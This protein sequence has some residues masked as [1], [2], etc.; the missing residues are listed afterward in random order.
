MKVTERPILHPFRSNWVLEV[1]ATCGKVTRHS[2]RTLDVFH[3][4][5]LAFALL[6]RF[7][8]FLPVKVMGVSKPCM[9]EETEIFKLFL[10]DIFESKAV[11]TSAI[12]LTFLGLQDNKFEDWASMEETWCPTKRMQESSDSWFSNEVFYRALEYQRPETGSKN[13]L[14]SFSLQTERT[15]RESLLKLHR[16]ITRLQSALQKQKSVLTFAR[17]ELID[18]EDLLPW[19][20][21]KPVCWRFQLSVNTGYQLGLT[22]LSQESRIRRLET[23]HALE[24]AGPG[25]PVGTLVALMQ[26]NLLEKYNQLLR[27][28]ECCEINLKNQLLSKSTSSSATVTDKY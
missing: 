26:T 11:F 19:A 8:E 14:A 9:E 22:L 21:A 4:D 2:K 24:Q 17:S 3:L 7:P 6:L 5:R 20:T 15:M 18:F 16:R 1:E 12:F 10:R 23:E 13:D 28:V 25:C 27:G